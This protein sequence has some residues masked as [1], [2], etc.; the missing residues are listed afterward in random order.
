MLLIINKCFSF[1]KKNTKNTGFYFIW[2]KLLQSNFKLGELPR[3]SDSDYTN[4]HHS[5]DFLAIIRIVC[6]ILFLV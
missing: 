3:N 2:G 5:Y 6:D 4:Y 1:E